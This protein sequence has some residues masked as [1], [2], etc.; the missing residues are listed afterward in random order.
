MK[1]DAKSS[2]SSTLVVFSESLC[3]YLLPQGFLTGEGQWQIDS[4]ESHPVDLSLPSWPVPPHGGV[5][6]GAHVLVIPET[7]WKHKKYRPF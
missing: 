4:I 6:K 2:F 7:G 5:A 1:T 3:P